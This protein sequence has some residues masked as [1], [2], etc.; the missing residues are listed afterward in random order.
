M[1]HLIVLIHDLYLLPKIEISGPSMYGSKGGN[2]GQKNMGFLSNS[3]PD[4]LK[5]H[6]QPSQHSTL[7]NHRPA[8]ETPFKWRFAGGPMM[9]HL[10]LYLYHVSRHEQKKKEFKKKTLSNLDPSEKNFLDPRMP[11]IV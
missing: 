1:W 2:R 3:G 10:L 7:G 8:S 5:K 6:K 4:P 9:A 11:K